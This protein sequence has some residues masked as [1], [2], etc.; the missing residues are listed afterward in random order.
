MDQLARK[1][2]RKTTLVLAAFVLVMA[3]ISAGTWFYRYSR[4]QQAKQLS[5]QPAQ[6]ARPTAK[7]VLAPQPSSSSP[8]AMPEESHLPANPVPAKPRFQFSVDPMLE[9]DEDLRKALLGELTLTF[10]ELP[11]YLGADPEKGTDAAYRNFTF[12]LL[13][14]AEKVRGNRQPATLLA[15]D[16]LASKI[17]CPEE[18]KEECDQVRREFVQRN[19]SFEHEALGGGFYY[20]RDLLWRIWRDYPAD[21]AGERTFVLLLGLGW[22]TSGICAKGSDQ[23]REVIRQGELFLQDRPTSPYRGIVSLLVGQAYAAWWA[24]GNERSSE[25]PDY[26]DPKRYQAGADEARL[27]AI[28]YFELVLQISPSTQ[29][30]NYASQA[31]APLR[32]E[33]VPEQYKF[34]CIYD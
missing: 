18:N 21:D 26:V 4:I 9:F 14:V 11:S 15:A 25:M 7:T 23:F 33:Q 2:P 22:D 34:V 24:L 8:T 5:A 6:G 10:P 20:S 17:W 16:L 28:H 1:G 3:G 13:D 27:N 12:H 29:L 19:L 32:L 31:I 30:A